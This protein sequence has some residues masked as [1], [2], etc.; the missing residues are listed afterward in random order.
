MPSLTRVSLPNA[1]LCRVH[2]QLN[3]V[4]YWWEWGLDIGELENHPNIKN[5]VLNIHSLDEL[6]TVTRS[7]VVVNVAENVCNDTSVTE[8]SFRPFWNLRVLQIGNGSFAHVNEFYLYAVHLLERVVIGRDC[9]T[10]P[11]NSCCVRQGYFH[12]RFCERLKE[13]RIGCNSFSDYT[14]WEI[15][16]GERLE[17]IEIGKLNERSDNFLWADLRLE[18]SSNGVSEE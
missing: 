12:L 3:S 6:S 13:I 10:I 18:S 8:L 5:P 15:G 1:F 17:V 11:D 4:S 14:V 7:L 2:Y 16:D 9:F